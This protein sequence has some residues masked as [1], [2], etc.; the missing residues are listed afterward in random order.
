VRPTTI[1]SRLDNESF[2]LETLKVSED[3]EALIYRLQNM[4]QTE[5]TLRIIDRRKTE[6][7]SLTDLSEK[8]VKRLGRRLKVPAHG[9][10]NLRVEL[11]GQEVYEND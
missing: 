9:L 6:V 3:G 4:A 10:V 2:V 11:A 8:P 1:L 5:Q 7:I